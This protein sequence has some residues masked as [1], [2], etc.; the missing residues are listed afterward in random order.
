MP[1]H[2]VPLTKSRI[3]VGFFYPKALAL[4]LTLLVSIITIQMLWL[5]CTAIQ[6]LVAPKNPT[7]TQKPWVE[8]SGD[9]FKRPL[10]KQVGTSWNYL[11]PTSIYWFHTCSN[12]VSIWF[13][14]V[15]LGSKGK[16]CFVLYLLRSSP[17]PFISYQHN[18]QG[19]TLKRP[20]GPLRPLKWDVSGW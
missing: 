20:Y 15:H 9:W 6:G 17:V 19:Y 3:E 10:K 4:D 12:N 14:L 13:I 11:V 1:W 2:L 18:L 8:Y 5:K 16:D 7:S